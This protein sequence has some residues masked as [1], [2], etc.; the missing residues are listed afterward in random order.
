[1]RKVFIGNTLGT[2]SALCYMFIYFCV[3]ITLKLLNSADLSCLEVTKCVKFQ[4]PRYKGFKVG[5]YFHLHHC[6]VYYSSVI[7]HW[8]H[9]LRIQHLNA[10]CFLA[11]S[12]FL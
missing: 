3:A 10:W 11:I 9:V 1:M 8:L 2:F 4:I 5:T 7:C 6:D 12:L